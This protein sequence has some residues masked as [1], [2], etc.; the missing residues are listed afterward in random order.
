MNI[1]PL[2]SQ[3]YARS[4]KQFNS[5]GKLSNTFCT[6]QVQNPQKGMVINMANLTRMGGFAKGVAIGVAAGTAIGIFTAPKTKNVRR[7]ASKFIRTASDIIDDVS[8]IWH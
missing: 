2:T 7:A 4:K 8:A 3:Y 1:A 5:K 6:S